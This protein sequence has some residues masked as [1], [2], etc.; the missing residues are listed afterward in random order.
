MRQDGTFNGKGITKTHFRGYRNG[1][2]GGRPVWEEAKAKPIYL[3]ECGR[4]YLK[5]RPKQD[6]CHNCFSG[7]DV[8][9]KI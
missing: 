5:T 8:Y 7:V 4:K 1:P 6:K 3:C 9:K 2:L